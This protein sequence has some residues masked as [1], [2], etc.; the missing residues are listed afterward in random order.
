MHQQA[1]VARVSEMAQAA[2]AISGLRCFHR[3]GAHHET[4]VRRN[5]Q[6]TRTEA[7]MIAIPTVVKPPVTSVSCQGRAPRPPVIGERLAA[8][9][10][11]A[12]VVTAQLSK[13]PYNALQYP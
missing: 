5:P 9:T 1:P 12:S 4:A 10:T 6:R 2:R 3:T 13:V 7:A 11:A 8:P